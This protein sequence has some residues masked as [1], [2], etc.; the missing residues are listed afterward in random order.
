MI[1]AFLAIQPAEDVLRNLESLQIEFGDTGADV[2]WVRAEA[3]HLTLQFLGEVRENEL[4][5][6]ERGLAEALREQAPVEIEC[7][8]LGVFPNQK[9]PRVVWVGLHGAGLARVAERAETV[10]SPLGFPP[11]EREFTPHITLGRIRSTRGWEQLQRVLKVSADRSLGSSRIDHA[12]LY[13]SELRPD[14]A[15]YTALATFPFAG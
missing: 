11:E 3:M 4:P 12:T 7:R 10:L 14:H 13:R 5:A 6:I 9:R 2:R 1:R 15:V 8:G